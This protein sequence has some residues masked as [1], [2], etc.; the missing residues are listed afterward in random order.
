MKL[1]RFFALALLLSVTCAVCSP[2]AD[3]GEAA[4]A[5]KEKETR[6]TRLEL[7]RGTVTAKPDDK[8]HKE[9]IDVA[10]QMVV[11]PLNRKSNQREP[12]KMD[13]YFQALETDLRTLSDTKIKA[14]TQMASRMYC[15][16]VAERAMDVI[17]E[18]KPIAQINAARMVARILDKAPKQSDSA[19]AED[20]QGRLGGDNAEYFANN[21]AALVKESK[22][23]GVRYWALRGLRQLFAVP[24]DKNPIRGKDAELK[25]IR[26]VM[27]LAEKQVKFPPTA[28]IREIDGYRVLRREAVRALARIPT[29][30]V[31]DKDAPAVVLAR[32]AGNDERII[33]RPRVDERF[34]AALGLARMKPAAKDKS[35][36][37][38][39]AAYCIGRGAAEFAD[40]ADAELSIDPKTGQP[41]SRPWKVDAARFLDALEAFKALQ[42]E[43]KNAYAKDV[44]DR[45]V[46]MLELVEKGRD[47][48]APNLVNWLSANPPPNKQLIK[49]LD[50]AT[51]KEPG[52]SE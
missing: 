26:E 47:A 16:R 27:Q 7:F 43:Q 32:F 28:T 31:G 23:D 48:K 25:A 17:K 14:S 45:V 22:N 34:E 4:M 30:R 21:L 24:A 20:V 1:F 8:D 11:E 13:R 12:G 46:P 3:E 5:R 39:Y 33:P 42:V 10:A 15:R 41:K 44:L 35:Y 38:D 52:P 19:W 18:G 51:V 2:G 36:N 9:A 37:V 6:S 50:D 49:E 40:R 29:P